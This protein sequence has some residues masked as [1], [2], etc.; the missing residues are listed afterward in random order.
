M[1]KEHRAKLAAIAENRV[2]PNGQAWL[3]Q[4]FGVA[5]GNGRELW[6]SSMGTQHGNMRSLSNRS[7][8]RQTSSVTSS[9]STSD[10]LFRPLRA[11]LPVVA[12]DPT[13]FF[14]PSKNPL[15][16]CSDD[17]DCKRIVV[18]DAC[19]DFNDNGPVS[20]PGHCRSGS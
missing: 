8:L 10:S 2:T 13:S 11:T 19:A 14:N 4:L 3:G 12:A 17:V 20:T 9:C 18:K 7:T 16:L 5:A 6:H 1:I 15:S